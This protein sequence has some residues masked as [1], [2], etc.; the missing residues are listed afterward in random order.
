MCV[1]TCETKALTGFA[2]PLTCY[3]GCQC[4]P[5]FVESGNGDCIPDTECPC[6]DVVTDTW[7]Q[8]GYPHRLPAGSFVLNLTRNIKSKIGNNICIK[9]IHDNYIWMLFLS[10][11]SS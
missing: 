6:Y 8:V 2:C 9:L 3:P 4:A 5:G 11:P 1:Q 10:M 7:N